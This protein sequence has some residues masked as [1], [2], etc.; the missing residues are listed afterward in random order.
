MNIREEFMHVGFTPEEKADLTARLERAAEQEENM[1]ASTKRKIKKISG[2]MVFGI[3][4][5]CL[6]TV[7]TLAAVLSPGLKDYFDAPGPGAQEALESGIYRLDRSETYNGWTVTLA[8]CIGDDDKLCIWV[9]LTAPEGTALVCNDDQWIDFTLGLDRQDSEGLGYGTE[10]QYMPDESPTDNKLSCCFN[11]YPQQSLRGR[12]LNL[13]VGPMTDVHVERDED[14]SVV[15]WQRGNTLTQAIQDHVW[16]FQDVALDYPDQTVRLTPNVEIPYLDGTAALTGLEI[17]PLGMTARVEGGSCAQFAQL[18]ELKEEVP[19]AAGDITTIETGDV[20]VSFGKTTAAHEALHLLDGWTDALE[21]SLHMRDGSVQGTKQFSYNFSDGLGGED[22]VPYLERQLY[23][24]S[25][26]PGLD[27][28][29]DP[30]QV[31]YVTVCGVDIPMPEP[32]AEKPQ[33]VWQ[34]IFEHF[35]KNSPA[36]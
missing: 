16:T 7:G 35:W 25:E 13:T 4:A 2:G 3:A 1:T 36:G 27:Q 19:P 32:P 21:V 9:D 22:D 15:S 17:S 29:I 18:N 8:E 10:S 23:Y 26:Q 11:L 31:D 5:A 28:V 34:Q 14:G 33:S 12:T 20:I 30:A 24:P 6:M